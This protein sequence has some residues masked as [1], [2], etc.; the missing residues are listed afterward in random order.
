MHLRNMFQVYSLVHLVSLLHCEVGEGI[1]L[2]SSTNTN[3]PSPTPLY[4]SV[5]Q[6][7]GMERGELRVYH[8]LLIIVFSTVIFT[9][10]C[11]V[12]G[13]CKVQEF[14]HHY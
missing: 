3:Q 9:C 4:G 8:S 11:L 14:C 6:P 10:F 12:I 7:S 13:I 1:I 2:Q 5:L